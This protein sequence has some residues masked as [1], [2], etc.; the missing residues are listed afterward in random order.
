MT[1]VSYFT[2]ALGN[3]NLYEKVIKTRKSGE[4]YHE[5]SYYNLYGVVI[6]TITSLVVI[7]WKTHTLL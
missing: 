6:I 3:F 7:T 5:I 1:I 4:I 2:M